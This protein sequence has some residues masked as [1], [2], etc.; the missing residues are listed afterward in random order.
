[1]K[2]K[3]K[4]SI[5]ETHPEL[6]AQA[7]GWDPT[8]VTAGSEKTK[9]WICTLG[10]KFQARV[11]NRVRGTGCPVCSNRQI[12]VGF[13]DLATTH[14]EIAAEAH[15]W[16]PTTVV[17]G[18]NLNQNWVCKLNHTWITD[19]NHRTRRGD[20]CPYCS[21]NKVLAGFN[22]LATINPELAAEADGWDPTTV[23]AGSRLKVQWKCT[24]AHTWEA[25]VVNRTNLSNET[26]CPYCSGHKVWRGFNDLATINP[27]LAAE[28]D[29]W[30]PETVTAGSGKKVRWK[31]ANAHTWEAV[32][33]S[34]TSGIGCP[35][36][37]NKMVL[38]GYNDLK[39][40]HP[41]IAAEA[42]GWDPSTVTSG[43]EGKRNWI[44][45]LGHKYNSR[46]ANRGSHGSGCPVCA[47]L[48]LLVGYN[49]LQT[50]RPDLALQ[51]DGWDPS[52]VVSGAAS[53]Q[54]WRCSQQHKWTA[55]V[56]ARMSGKGCPICSNHVI[57]KGYNDLATT[58]P[59][60]IAEADGWDTTKVIAGSG[61]KRKWICGFGHRWMATT[62][63]RAF[64]NKT[65]CP[66]C[67]KSGFD[68]NKDAWLYFIE[69]DQLQMLQIG[70]TNYPDSRLKSH[71][72]GGWEIIEL[73]G[74]MDGHLTQIMETNCLHALEK[75]G[76]VLGHKAKIESFDGYSEAWTKASLTVTSIKQIFDWVYEDEG[77]NNKP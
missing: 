72:R 54:K 29:G 43:S 45:Q 44:C 17:P 65:G 15:G 18:S 4:P 21:G 5:A 25:T 48:K 38:P 31:C 61:I 62:R 57:L 26:G 1:V 51:A 56:D 42:D 2:S 73:R 67:A 6:A 46:I 27:E 39:T 34:R 12:L 23:T 59:E 8:T 22:D 10:H 68:P 33:W 53:K 55:T 60:L 35:M 32:V 58:H 76:A 52:T 64:G 24:K 47:N 77:I 20:G 41:E 69:H 13:N 49:D 28:A 19:P 14:P 66:S 63:A 71:K 74:P 11:N 37:S 9:D 70:I 3:S 40:T 30:N 16:D 75:R 7:E 36:C 50:A